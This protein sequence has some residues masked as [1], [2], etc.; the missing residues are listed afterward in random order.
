[1][2]NR[3]RHVM[4]ECLSG[5][6][7]RRRRRQ[8]K[9]EERA[10]PGVVGVG[11]AVVPGVVTEVL[12]RGAPAGAGSEGREADGPLDE[13]PRGGGGGSGGGGGGTR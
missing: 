6:V 10:S 2:S 5:K 11:E 1:M 8:K 3:A 7:K 13:G 4:C 12:H 9:T